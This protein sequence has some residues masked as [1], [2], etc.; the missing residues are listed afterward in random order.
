MAGLENDEFGDFSDDLMLAALEATE[1][2]AAPAGQVAQAAMVA[3]VNSQTAPA[4]EFPDDLLL[5]ALEQSERMSQVTPVD[6]GLTSEEAAAVTHGLSEE[7]ARA[8]L[9]DSQRPQPAQKSSLFFSGPG[10]FDRV[11][12]PIV[13]ISMR[14][15]RNVSYLNR[16]YGSTTGLDALK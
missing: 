8:V 6:S 3:P 16:F 10:D 12:E 7:Q 9:A 11:S 13:F 4:D 1:Q 5:A 14:S 15:I 2:L